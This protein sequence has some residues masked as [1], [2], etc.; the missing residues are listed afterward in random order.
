MM[1]DC[2]FFF[3]I[4]YGF[5][6]IILYTSSILARYF[7]PIYIINKIDVSIKYIS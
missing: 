6:D 7:F 5:C 3:V 2:S 1:A 4:K